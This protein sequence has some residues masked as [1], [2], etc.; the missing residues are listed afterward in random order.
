MQSRSPKVRP[1]SSRDGPDPTDAE[2]RLIRSIRRIVS[3]FVVSAS[4]AAVPEP[5]AQGPPL[6]NFLSTRRTAAVW[7][8]ASAGRRS[9]GIDVD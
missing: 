1:G 4:P 6:N 2:H 9:E 5:R 8:A 3:N 7:T